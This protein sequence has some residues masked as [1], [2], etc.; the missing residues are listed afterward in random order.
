MRFTEFRI[1]CLMGMLL[2]GF[3]LVAAESDIQFNRD[4]RPILAEH[5]LHCHGPDEK[6][7]EG[8]LRLDDEQAA[9]EL[10]IDV[11]N[12]AASS[13]IER[14]TSSDPELRM[15]PPNSKTSLSERETNILKQWVLEGAAYQGHWAFEPI[16]DPPVPPLRNDSSEFTE[17]DHFIVSRL[18]SSGLSLT[19]PVTRQQWIR[20][21]TQDLIGLPPTWEEV[22]AFV[23]D[24]SPDAH[25]K[26]LD[27]LLATPRYGERWGRHWLDIARYA[28]T[29]G[30]SAI[31]FQKFPFSY[32]YRDY[33]INAFNADVPYNRFV[34]EQLA[35]DQ[36]DLEE[37]DPALAGLGFLTIGMQFRNP[38]DVIDDQID[39]TT[40]GL[41]GLTAACA[42]CHDHKYDP[43]PT[44]DYYALYATFA[45]S[46]KPELPPTVGNP[47]ETPAYQQYAVELKKRQTVYEDM[48]RDQSQVMRG[49]L[50][51]QV[52]AYLRELAKGVPEQD[53][54][55]A[56]LS[57]RTDDVRP[58][59]LNRWR[60]YLAELRDDDPVFGPW[61]SLSAL[62]QMEAEEFNKA[63]LEQIKN[64]R[65]E[66]GDPATFA[67]QHQIAV[68]APKWNP[69]VL[70]ALEA[71]S[72]KS[73]L[74][75][76]DAYGTLFAE[77]HR[78]W[79]TAQLEASL[80]ASEDGTVIPDQD[81][82]HTVVN[83][84]MNQQ[85]RR[86]LYEPGT[87]TAM[88]LDTATTLLNRTVRDGLGG[89][90]GAI[91]GLHLSSPGS[92]PRAM[93]L[94]ESETAGPFYVFRRGNPLS[95]GDAVQAHTLTAFTPEGTSPEPFPEGQRRL[96]LALDLTSVENPLLRRVVANW[97]WQR[98]F[99][100]GLVRTLDDFGTRSNPP[101][102][103][104]L[105]DYL[106]SRLVDDGWS[107]KKLHKR[108]MLSQVYRQG[109]VEN[110][111]SRAVDSDNNL[112]W[113]MPRR[114]L[115]METMRDSMLAV[116]GE[117]D[118]RR[119]GGRP[120]DFL[121]NPIVPR[122]SVYGFINRDIIHSLA[123]TFDA[124]NPTSC[125]ATRPTT[126]VPQQ[127][128][129]AL[130][131]AFIQDRAAAFAKLTA[132]TT[133]PATRIQLMYQRAYGR[134]PEPDEVEAALNFVG[135]R[136]AGDTWLQL[137]HALLA[138]NEFVFAD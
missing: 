101:T 54:A 108:I 123:S 13:L 97:V 96:A 125:S 90:H 43:I 91:E 117:L 53:L 126:T 27:R 25:E 2:T 105:L 102:H 51:M 4:I 120:F 79:L 89:K 36:L 82:R 75:V 100:Q 1:S 21:A 104:E 124:A 28:D 31:G 99:G 40:R 114:H 67:N 24:A 5:C 11:T 92:P 119:I 39:V 127:T 136:D 73:L 80:E 130:N 112:L 18:E 138:S 85:V 38:H 46:S 98:H 71:K 47:P 34:Q 42:R 103:P 128:L 30:G 48:A 63:T 8:E 15:P 72:P 109:A 88:D 10:A 55:S 132:A 14:I 87:P 86:H 62:P 76:A 110:A 116:S 64:W 45:S 7:R 32:T 44:S 81:G 26:V 29:H 121:A 12:L 33:V 56:F 17:I 111:A 69:R 19:A 133:D 57:Y 16:H 95:R 129:F 22:E 106:A 137:A 84:A 52:G 58:L 94:Q 65:E 77:V 66:N 59:V 49:R 23:N 135:Q 20:R 41:L 74:E 122:R 107:L 50:R 60:D 3:S 131:S 83:S 6:T 70:D 68:A 35:A 134:N 93:A 61:K 37:N 113:R 115:D 78:E 9:K 118:V